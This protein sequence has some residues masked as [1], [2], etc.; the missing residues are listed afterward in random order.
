MSSLLLRQFYSLCNHISINLGTDR[1]NV[2]VTNS[3]FHLQL[4]STETD[5]S[6]SQENLLIAGRSLGVLL[7]YF[8][9]PCRCGRLECNE[10]RHLE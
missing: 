9:S 4:R 3:L 8:Y 6:H 2:P 7:R 5:L 1:C 10:K